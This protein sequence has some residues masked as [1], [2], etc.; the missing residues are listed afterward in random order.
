MSRAEL[1]SVVDRCSP[2]DQRY[3]LAYLRT[4]D[5]EFR[6]KLTTAD[7]EVSSGRGIRLRATRRGLVR[8]AV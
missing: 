3:L 8:A 6:R 5:P 2:A 4:K 1:K 7:R